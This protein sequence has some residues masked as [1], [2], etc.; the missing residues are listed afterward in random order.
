[1]IKSLKCPDTGR[2]FRDENVRKFVNI[3]QP[4]RRKLLMLHAAKRLMDLKMPP[5]NRLHQLER[6][7]AGQ[8]SISIND[9]WRICFVW[10]D[11]DAYDVEITDYH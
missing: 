4:A 6:D 1:M 8:H 10:R 2:L 11:G 3:R 5:G 7:R 9:Q